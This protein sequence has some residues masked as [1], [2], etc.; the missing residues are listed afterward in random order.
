MDEKSESNEP[1]LDKRTVICIIAATTITHYLTCTSRRFL[2]PW[3]E[4]RDLICR[5]SDLYD[6]YQKNVSK[7]F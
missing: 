4:W 2:L 5:W 1:K 7:W 6:T 3:Y